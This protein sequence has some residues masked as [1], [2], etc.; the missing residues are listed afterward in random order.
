MLD[1]GGAPMEIARRLGYEALD[2]SE[3]DSV[4]AD[5]ITDH[6]DEWARFLAGEDKVEQFLTGQVM[7]RTRGRANGKVV[8]ESFAR[9]R[10]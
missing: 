3:L 4:I 9:R 10:G 6:P 1:E 2:P 8:A 7:R 5:V